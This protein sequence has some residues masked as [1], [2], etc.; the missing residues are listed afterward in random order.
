MKFLDTS[1]KKKSAILTA[2]IAVL[3]LLLFF[4][5]F[6][7]LLFLYSRRHL[8]FVKILNNRQQLLPD[9]PVTA[10][11][12]VVGVLGR[13]HP[14]PNGKLALFGVAPSQRLMLFND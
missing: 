9:A 4:M 13:L 10:Q 12:S 6:F 11:G 1:L 3:I 5:S 7:L 14:H 2:A 8:M